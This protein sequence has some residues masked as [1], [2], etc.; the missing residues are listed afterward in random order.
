MSGSNTS[1]ALPIYEHKDEILAAVSAHPVVFVLGKTSCGKSSQV[2]QFLVSHEDKL[3]GSGRVILVQPRRL[4]ATSLAR[5]IAAERGYDRIEDSDVG[6][7]IGGVVSPNADSAKILVVTYGILMNILESGLARFSFIILDEIHER[8]FEFDVSLAILRGKIRHAGMN[9]KLVLM[10]AT[11]DVTP[12]AGYLKEYDLSSATITI[13]KSVYKVLD[14]VLDDLVEKF[15]LDHKAA[16]DLLS[17]PGVDF[18]PLFTPARR[19]ALIRLVSHL[20][21]QTPVS[22]GIIVFLTG[23]SLI[24]E[25][26]QLIT[27]NVVGPKKYEI[28]P[29]HS[30]YPLEEQQKAVERR[31]GRRK[32]SSPLTLTSLLHL[33]NAFLPFSA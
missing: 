12:L 4:V 25:V 16:S 1:G 23:I 28:I 18:S 32:A 11:V 19:T 20:H 14:Y 6:F 30:S 8:G 33:F 29:L 27:E 5:R 10:S 13:S 21:S 26:A 9:A 31:K 3:G 22:A 7:K 15:Q 24:N 2:P 17:P